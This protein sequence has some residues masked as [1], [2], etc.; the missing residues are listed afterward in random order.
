MAR[1]RTGARGGVPYLAPAEAE[2]ARRVHREQLRL[3]LV[4][5]ALLAA[6]IIGLMVLL[7]VF[8]GLDEVRV[9]GVPVSWLAVAVLPYPLLNLLARWQLRGAE[10]VERRGGPP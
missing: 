5:V 2:R 8:P 10:R 6:L 9:A 7:R 4:T 1:R 3:A